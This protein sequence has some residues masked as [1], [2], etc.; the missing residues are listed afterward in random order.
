[1]LINQFDKSLA[2]TIGDD[3]QLTAKLSGDYTYA[4]GDSVTLTVVRDQNAEPLF[5]ASAELDSSGAA[6]IPILAE[7][8]KGAESGLYFYDIQLVMSTDIKT[9]V[10]WSK[11]TLIPE[12]TK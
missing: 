2:M 7:Y 10:P 11:F 9:I 8:T 12:A 1:M 3:E 5:T 6:T 4:E